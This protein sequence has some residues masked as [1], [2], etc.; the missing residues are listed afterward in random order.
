MDWHGYIVVQRLNIGIDNWN[1]LIVLFEDMGTEGS[2]MP[3]FNTHWRA[4][5]DG[6]A[7]IYESMFDTS[8]VSVEAFKQMLADEFSV[9]VEDIDDVQTEESYAGGTTTVWTFIYSAIDRF[10]VERFGDGGSNWPQSGDECRGY[11]KLHRDQ[12]ELEE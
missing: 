9:P 1:T 5:L 4:T 8:E 3:A 11:L 6:D 12:W 10:K 7:V 2:Q